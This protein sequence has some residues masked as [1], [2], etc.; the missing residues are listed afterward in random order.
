MKKTKEQ[1]E[2]EQKQFLRPRLIDLAVGAGVDDV[3][4]EDFWCC[5][6]ESLVRLIRGVHISFDKELPSWLKGRFT[7]YTTITKYDS[8]NSLFDWLWDLGVRGNVE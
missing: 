6:N 3:E 2:E 4:G 7:E 5:D 8:L 1:L